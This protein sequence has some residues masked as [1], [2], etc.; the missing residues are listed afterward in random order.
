M[1][2]SSALLSGFVVGLLFAFFPSCTPLPCSSTCLAGCCDSSG[3]CQPG[4]LSTACGKGGQ[5]CAACGATQSCQANTCV[6]GNGGGGDGGSGDGGTGGNCGPGNCSGCCRNGQCVN[7]ANTKQDCGQAGGDCQTCTGSQVCD[8]SFFAC[9]DLNCGGCSDSTGMCMTGDQTS[10]CGKLGYACKACA[11]G[12]SCVQGACTTGGGG[13]DGGHDGG[14]GSIACDTTKQ[15][16]PVGAGSCMWTDDGHGG[17]VELCMPGACDLVK[18]DCAGTGTMCAYDLIDA[19]VVGRACVPEGAVAVGA[20]CTAQ[21]QATDCQK[22]SVCASGICREFCN[23]STDCAGGYVCSGSGGYNNSVEY[24]MYCQPPCNVF[25][26]DCTTQGESCYPTAAGT[27]CLTT[28]ATANGQA[29][30]QFNSCLPRSMCVG[31][32]QNTYQ[33]AALCITDGGVP[34]TSGTCEALQGTTDFGVCI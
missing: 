2:L 14:H 18:Q 4:A 22:G 13:T 20:A 8:S 17:Y 26:Q 34:C 11:S 15:N 5:A 12:Q 29:C 1:K 32:A 31:V 33:C 7:P 28:G 27:T 25:T 3:V 16:C 30:T 10:A 21:S 23:T 6:E 19:G 24:F 9:R